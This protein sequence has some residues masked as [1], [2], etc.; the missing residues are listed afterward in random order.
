MNEIDAKLI[1]SCFMQSSSMI[2]DAELTA[3]S[4]LKSIERKLLDS[5]LSKL[6]FL[7]VLKR[8]LR[9]SRESIKRAIGLL[10]VGFIAFV[11]G[12]TITIWTFMGNSGVILITYGPIIFGGGFL[13]YAIIDFFDDFFKKK[14]ILGWL[15]ELGDDFRV[16]D[17]DNLIAIKKFDLPSAVINLINAQLDK[18]FK[19]NEFYIAETLAP[20]G[21][22][23][24]MICIDI[25]IPEEMIKRMTNMIYQ[26]FK[27]VFLVYG[28]NS[29]YFN[30]I[31]SVQSNF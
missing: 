1:R 29:I 10:I 4:M 19:E 3:S 5:E 20:N 9:N 8:E 6:I 23:Y 28:N 7:S 25:A 2:A 17:F 21:E 18:T 24:H 11:I 12:A 13:I 26:N 16:C 22:L 30:W 15:Q 31:K 27:T 14:D